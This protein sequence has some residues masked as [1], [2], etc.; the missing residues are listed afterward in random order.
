MKKSTKDAVYTTVAVTGIF[1]FV[2]NLIKMYLDNRKES[3]F[4]KED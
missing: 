2:L 1:G 4:R 3:Q